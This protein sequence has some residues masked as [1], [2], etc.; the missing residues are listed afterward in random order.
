MFSLPSS[1]S[2]FWGRVVCTITPHSRQLGGGSSW[3]LQL[4]APPRPV[5]FPHHG[6]SLLLGCAGRILWLAK[7]SAEWRGTLE[8]QVGGEASFAGTLR[9][10][11][12]LLLRGTEAHTARRRPGQ[13]AS[14]A[15][16]CSGSGPVKPRADGAREALPVLRWGRGGGRGSKNGQAGQPCAGSSRVALDSLPP[17]PESPPSR[18]LFLAAGSSGTAED[19][20]SSSCGAGGTEAK[21][22]GHSGGEHGV[23]GTHGG[24]RAGDTTTLPFHRLLQLP[25]AVGTGWCLHWLPGPGSRPGEARGSSGVWDGF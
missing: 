7:A 6:P 12:H 10:G 15:L 18:W 9:S 19:G 5:H 23:P 22:V 16:L 20:S 11:S 13:T 2:S 24:L 25:C 1:F 3:P 8:L 21:S 14:L 4:A 17:H